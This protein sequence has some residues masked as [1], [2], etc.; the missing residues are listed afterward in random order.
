M[1]ATGLL[2]EAEP[3]ENYLVLAGG[4]MALF[5]FLTVQMYVV[6]RRWHRPPASTLEWAVMWSWKLSAV[7]MMPALALLSFFMS[8]ASLV[9]WLTG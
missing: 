4:W 1:Y 5:V 7:T 3:K 9:R 8:L 2:A 6:W